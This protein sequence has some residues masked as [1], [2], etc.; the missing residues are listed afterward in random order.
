MRVLHIITDLDNGGAEAI[1]FRLIKSTPDIEHE[2]FSLMSGGIYEELIRE[3]GVNVISF[4]FNK[5]PS[6]SFRLIKLFYYIFK[7][8][9]DVVQTWMYHADFFGGIF[10]KLIFKK[11]IVWGI[12]GPF[13]KR[14]TSLTTKL[15]IYF[16]SFLSYIVPHNIIVVSNHALKRHINIGYNKNKFIL[17]N[18]GYS[19]TDFNFVEGSKNFVLN[20]HKIN[21]DVIVL[22]MVARYDPYK[23]H[24]NLFKAL[25]LLKSSN[26]NF[27]CL[28]IGSNMT[29]ENSDLVK[30]IASY[31][32]TS[33]VF[34]I[35]PKS[36]ISMYM[37]SLDIHI[38]S[39]LDES[40]PNV[41]SEAMLCS[42]PCIST[43]VGD[44]EL[45]LGDTGWIV[46]IKDPK[47]LYLSIMEAIELLVSDNI[48]WAN[49]KQ[50]CR[51]RIVLNFSLQSMINSYISVWN[52]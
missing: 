27:V 20:E 17:I 5:K 11:K 36:N 43:D 47:K 7:S 32:L 18:N 6:D 21:E 30:M 4:N 15:F 42:T 41:L 14:N 29:C 12:H 22:G 31:D 10:S 45:I 50:L 39:S 28:L 40:F 2:V 49:K 51:E 48:K 38:L 3:L 33:N 16:N 24:E 35:G 37:S 19:S 9:C 8:R 52:N 25:F 44:A 23:D 46:P 34:L 13:N 1:L 26:F